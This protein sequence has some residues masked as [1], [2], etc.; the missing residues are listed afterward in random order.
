MAPASQ[1]GPRLRIF[2]GGSRLPGWPPPPRFFGLGGG[3]AGGEASQI[4][5]VEEMEREKEERRRGGARGGE[6]IP[7]TRDLM[8]GGECPRDLIA[9]H[10][11][12]HIAVI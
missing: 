3:V 9:M 1:G 7:N 10:Q 4:F 2:Q 11:S 5:G 6:E 12:F 8:S